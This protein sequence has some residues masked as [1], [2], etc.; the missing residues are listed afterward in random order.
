[1][2]HLLKPKKCQNNELTF[3]ENLKQNTLNFGGIFVD[4]FQKSGLVRFLGVTHLIFMENFRKIL[5][6]VSEEN[7]Y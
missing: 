5:R 3:L 2:E 4:V 1:M 7:H 6:A